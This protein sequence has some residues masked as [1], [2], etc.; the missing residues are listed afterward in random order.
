M[1]SPN[2]SAA[3]KNTKWVTHLA[4]SADVILGQ[5]KTENCVHEIQSTMDDLEGQIHKVSVNC[6]ARDVPEQG[7][8]L[9]SNVPFA[10]N[11]LRL[12]IADP[13][14]MRRIPDDMDGSD[15]AG[16]TLPTAP[17][18]LSAIAVIDGVSE[19]R[20]SAFFKGLTYLNKAH[21][22]QQFVFKGQFPDTP[23]YNQWYVPGARNLV[24][25]DCMVMREGGFHILETSLVRV[26]LLGPA[27]PALLQVLK[28]TAPGTD[29]RAKRIR[30]A[31][32]ANKAA[33]AEKDK[34]VADAGPSTPTGTVIEDAPSSPKAMPPP[35]SAQR[36]ITPTPTRQSAKRKN[37]E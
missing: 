37:G 18:T 26:T 2:N 19:D 12:G 10:T 4:L 11:P 27:P 22:W 24:H 3:T 34:D 5:A 30:Q 20:K 17:I 9:L 31:R 29:D 25:V 15:G 8:Y 1:T 21:Q 6:W 33:Q 28:I 16:P 35:P 32:E 23:K 7:V 14:T 36:P 13:G